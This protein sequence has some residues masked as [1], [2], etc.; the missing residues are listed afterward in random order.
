MNELTKYVLEQLR[1]NGTTFAL[2]ILAV[3]FFYSRTSYLEK[4]VEECN[5][6]YLDLGVKMMDALDRN[7]KAFEDLKCSNPTG[8]IPVILKP[9][10]VRK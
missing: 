9:Y 6:T 10:K 1:K 3:A 2:L 7:T 5:K 4:Q 8:E